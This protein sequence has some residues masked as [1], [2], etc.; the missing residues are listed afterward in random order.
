[1]E[2]IAK[3]AILLAPVYCWFTEGLDTPVL[4]QA[5]AFLDDPGRGSAARSVIFS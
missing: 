4:K 2:E 3:P 5:K 1:V